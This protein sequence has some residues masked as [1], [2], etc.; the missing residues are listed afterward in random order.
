M[1]NT[2]REFFL[3]KQAT[4]KRLGSKSPPAAQKQTWVVTPSTK[5]YYLCDE[6]T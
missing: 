2:K 3:K 5:K 4:P 6:M 1:E